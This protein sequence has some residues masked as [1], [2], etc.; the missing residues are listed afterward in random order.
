MNKKK[1]KTNVCSLWIVSLQQ[2]TTSSITL[3][4][5]LGGEEGGIVATTSR[6]A[7]MAE[8]KYWVTGQS[9]APT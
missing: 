4:A 6:P 2:L 5:G 1:T 9:P 8:S 7:C 3:L